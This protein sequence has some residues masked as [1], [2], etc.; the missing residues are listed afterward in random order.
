MQQSMLSANMKELSKG[1]NPFSGSAAIG[2]FIIQQKE[3]LLADGDPFL[4]NC[5]F[6]ICC[7]ILL[8]AQ[9][10]NLSEGSVGSSKTLTF[11]WDFFGMELQQQLHK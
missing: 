10:P 9:R 8:S 3:N 6:S 4:L 2:Q 11:S 5:G 1:I 7:S